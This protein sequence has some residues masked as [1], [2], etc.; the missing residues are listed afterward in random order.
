MQFTRDRVRATGGEFY[1]A[2]SPSAV[3]GVVKALS[4]AKEG[5]GFQEEA[6]ETITRWGLSWTLFGVVS[7]LACLLPLGGSDGF[8]SSFHLI[9]LRLSLRCGDYTRTFYMTRR[10]L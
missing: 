3:D 9:V 4:R 10:S 6:I 5:A 2:S 1:D 7:L 8:S